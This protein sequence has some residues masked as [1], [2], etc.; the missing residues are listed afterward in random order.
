MAGESFIW[1]GFAF[2]ILLFIALILGMFVFW[3][4]MIVDCAQ[5]K[6]KDNDK[7]VWILVLVFLGWLGATV[8]YFVIKR[9]DKK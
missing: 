1:L 4:W 2:L 5:R 6:M 9:S 8:Y 3:I 7:V